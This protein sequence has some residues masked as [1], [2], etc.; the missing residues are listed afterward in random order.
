MFERDVPG[1]EGESSHRYEE[2]DT[3]RSFGAARLMPVRPIT[4]DGTVADRTF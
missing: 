2:A 1:W 3:T 4:F